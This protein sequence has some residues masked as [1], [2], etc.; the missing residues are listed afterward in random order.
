MKSFTEDIGSYFAL[1]LKPHP[2]R[3]WLIVFVF[4]I[5]VLLAVVSF[6][7]YL[8]LG[9]R[10]GS[11]VGASTADV[12]TPPQVTRGE[13]EIVLESYRKRVLNFNERNFPV[14]TLFDPS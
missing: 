7:A 13:I 10:T 11:I 4:M 5:I 9:I 12:P 14:P 3:D 1:L 2:G 6:A 8:F